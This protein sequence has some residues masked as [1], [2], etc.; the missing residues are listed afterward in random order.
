MALGTVVLVVGLLIFAAISSAVKFH[1]A[2]ASMSRG[3]KAIS[4]LSLANAAAFSYAVSQQQTQTVQ[5]LAIGLALMVTG[6]AL[7]FWSLATTRFAALHLA[8]DNQCPSSLIR[9]GPYR[10]VRHPFY[11]AYLL[12]WLGCAVSA[13]HILSTALLLILGTIYA[14]AAVSEER[15]FDTSPHAQDY[16][17]YRQTAGLFWPKLRITH[18]D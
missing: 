8:F 2:S 16:S 9:S 7:F 5:P 6:G 14:V 15:A 12:F 18:C 17:A 3:M 4:I 11:A 1:F 13:Q 10:Y